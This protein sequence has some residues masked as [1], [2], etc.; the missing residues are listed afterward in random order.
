MPDD[1]MQWKLVRFEEV[2]NSWMQR[3]LPKDDIRFLVLDWVLGRRDDPYGGMRRDRDI[4]NLWFG[5]V[6]GTESAGTVVT[7][8]YWI[9][10]RT[11]VVRCDQIATLSLPI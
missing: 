4:P 6:D 8:S 5:R 10:E 2:I 9:F 1:P 11:R 7:C 3:E